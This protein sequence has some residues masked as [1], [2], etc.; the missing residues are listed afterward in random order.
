MAAELDYVPIPT[1][2]TAL[3]EGTWKTTVMAHGKPLWPAK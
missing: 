3:V 2:V 1:K